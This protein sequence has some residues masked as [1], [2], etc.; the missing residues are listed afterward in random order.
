M[1]PLVDT[2]TVPT[3]SLAQYLGGR[4]PA[5]ANLKSAKIKKVIQAHLEQEAV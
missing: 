4:K 5:V 2:L 1:Y 3:V